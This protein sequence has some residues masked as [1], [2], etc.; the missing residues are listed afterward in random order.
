MHSKQR[1]Q[2][3]LALSVYN[4]SFFLKIK[5][6][7][8]KVLQELVMLSIQHTNSK[9]RTDWIIDAVL[10]KKRFSYSSLPPRLSLRFQAGVLTSS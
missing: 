4:H 7:A 2:A 10:N 6:D 3:G 8:P 1:I 5:T 9:N